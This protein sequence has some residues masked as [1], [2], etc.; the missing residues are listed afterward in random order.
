MVCGVLGESFE[1]MFL[2]TKTGSQNHTLQRRQEELLEHT[3]LVG[4]MM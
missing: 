2:L 1:R 4:F 3:E